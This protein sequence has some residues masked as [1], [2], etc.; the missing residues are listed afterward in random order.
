LL[1][2]NKKETL[3]E[4][5]ASLGYETLKTGNKLSPIM[6]S[7]GK[8]LCL[9]SSK[10]PQAIE[11]FI[12][13]IDSM[14]LYHTALTLNTISKKIHKQL[15]Q[16]SLLIMIGDF[17]GD[18]DL[19]L[20]AQKHELYL[21]IIRDVFEENP[22]ILGDGIYTDPES[23]EQ[24]RFY[25]GKSARDSYAAKYEANDRKLMQHLHALGISYKKILSP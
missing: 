24:E 13:E 2:K 17:L 22:S 6:I 9:P 15:K 21:F 3:L 23:G 4:L 12:K 20:L 7:Q 10:K 14:P 1:F 16:K 8:A 11:H 25:F 5:T 19:S 18:I